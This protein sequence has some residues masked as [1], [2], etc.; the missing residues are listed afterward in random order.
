MYKF[1]IP[2]FVP[3]PIEA[4]SLPGRQTLILSVDAL[5]PASPLGQLYNTLF[6]QF[7]L[8]FLC[9]W[10]CGPILGPKGVRLEKPIP[11]DDATDLL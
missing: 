4:S 9:L 8:A 2:I 6:D 7:S 3:C 10:Q 11:T 5:V 1:Q